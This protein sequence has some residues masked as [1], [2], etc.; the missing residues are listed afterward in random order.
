LAFWAVGELND[1]PY[2]IPSSVIVGFKWSIIDYSQKIENLFAKMEGVRT[3]VLPPN[4][5]AVDNYFWYVWENVHTLTAAASSL[6]SG[7]D[8]AERFKLHLEAEEARLE[9]NLR[10]VDY[11]IDG[12]DTLKLITGGGRI[13]K[14]R[15]KQR[16]LDHLALIL[17]DHRPSFH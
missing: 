11:V 1:F 12:I 8:D 16:T 2:P 6:S 4:R 3:T 9:K 15:T 14:V 17:F 13:E 5:A 7:L 10:A